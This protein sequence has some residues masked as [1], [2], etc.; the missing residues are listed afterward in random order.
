MD[1]SILQQFS[2]CWFLFD[3]LHT[4]NPI[5]FV[6]PLLNEINVVVITI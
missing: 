3:P 2:D 5:I 4:N 1:G 6:K